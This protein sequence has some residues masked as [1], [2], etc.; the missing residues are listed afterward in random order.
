MAEADPF[1]F[2]TKSQDDEADPLSYGYRFY[3]SATGRWLSRDPIEE[4]GG[5]NLY[6]L[7]G[8]DAVNAIDPVGRDFIAVGDRYVTYTPGLFRH[9]SIE[10]FEEPCPQT[11][12]GATFSIDTIPDSA[13]GPTDSFELQV[14]LHSYRHFFYTRPKP[15]EPPVRTFVWDFVREIRRSSTPRDFV[16]IYSDV[17]NPNAKARWKAIVAA[18]TTYPY[19]EQR[20]TR[21]TLFHWPNSQYE[22]FGNNS[23]TFVR[24]MATVIGRNADV[25]GGWHPGNSSA[26]PVPDPG[27]VPVFSPWG[28]E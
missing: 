5:A 4:E 23:N 21:G 26:V 20:A 15:T 25:I 14:L 16:V 6:D 17:D 22:L 10:F 3:N 28:D 11:P 9:M 8:T 1:R 2:S 19:G 13:K 7:A 24:E 18:A 27:Y 12:E